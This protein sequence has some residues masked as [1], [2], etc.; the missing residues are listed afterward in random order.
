M[1]LMQWRSLVDLPEAIS[2]LRCLVVFYFFSSRDSHF[3]H[4]SE[5]KAVVCSIYKFPRDHL[6]GM[7]QQQ[8]WRGNGGVWGNGGVCSIL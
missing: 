6:L 8:T 4:K 3:K 5:F 2:C 1:A 7:K